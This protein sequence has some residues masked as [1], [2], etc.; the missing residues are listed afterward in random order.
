DRRRNVV[1]EAAPLV[2]V[3]DEHGARPGGAARHSLVDL[4]Q[5][6]L[7]DAN[8]GV[9]MV[10]SR[11]AGPFVEEARVHVPDL[12]EGAGRAI[13]EERREGAAD[14]QVLRAPE[15]GERRVGEGVTAGPPRTRP[16]G[17]A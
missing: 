3:D 7:S 2:V 17:P 15:R 11:G 12:R 1:E 13:R 14:V 6:L 4:V 5:E 8:V 10:V 9:W 16:T